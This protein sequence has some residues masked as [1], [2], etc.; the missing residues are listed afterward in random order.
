VPPQYLP[1]QSL[2]LAVIL[3]DPRA[4]SAD[5]Q[6]AIVNI[7]PSFSRW[8]EVPAAAR[9]ND[10]WQ[11]VPPGEHS[12]KKKTNP[13]E[14]LHF[15]LFIFEC[16]CM[17]DAGPDGRR[18]LC[19]VTPTLRDQCCWRDAEA[20]VLGLRKQV[21]LEWVPA[22]SVLLVGVHAGGAHH[23]REPGTAVR[24]RHHQGAHE[25]RCCAP[26]CLMRPALS[27]MVQ[28]PSGASKATITCMPSVVCLCA[29]A[30][31]TSRS[32]CQPA[33]AASRPCT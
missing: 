26:R 6:Y 20:A 9:D 14:P 12:S 11:Q 2:N 21:L 24:R 29:A 13:C 16:V 28:T 33:P 1:S 18:K 32:E 19:F 10:T 25:C 23:Q 30:G 4:A 17:L 7:P 27:D 15:L 5:T 31:E 3:E 8:Y 22:N